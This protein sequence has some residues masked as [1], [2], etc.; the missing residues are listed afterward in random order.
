MTDV[1]NGD[2][3]ITIMKEP[4]NI[5]AYIMYDPDVP[6]INFI[7]LCDNLGDLVATKPFLRLI[8]DNLIFFLF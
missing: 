3:R 7:D 6:R 4:N 5:H 2:L 8:L 1:C